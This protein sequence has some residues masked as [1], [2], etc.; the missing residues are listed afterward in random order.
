MFAD[1]QDNHVPANI[2]S[3]PDEL[4][5]L[6]FWFC[7]PPHDHNRGLNTDSTRRRVDGQLPI[8]QRQSMRLVQRRWNSIIGIETHGFM[9]TP[10]RAKRGTLLA[11]CR[12]IR[13]DYS[14]S[15]G[16]RNVANVMAAAPSLAD[17]SIACALPREAL[18][19]VSLISLRS[20]TCPEIYYD[21]LEP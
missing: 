7:T 20:L 11:N 17:L 1:T 12:S 3:L 8:R 15:D 2:S 21:I 6:I 16:Y 13:L 4:L 5:L 19:E 10:I 14:G 9:S 18:G